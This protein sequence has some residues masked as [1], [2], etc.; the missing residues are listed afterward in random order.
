MVFKRRKTLLLITLL[1]FAGCRSPQPRSHRTADATIHSAYKPATSVAE[2]LPTVRLVSLDAGA[3]NA[4][5][6]PVVQMAQPQALPP[7]EYTF[8][9]SLDEA[10]G[11][12]LSQN[13]DLA[14]VRATEPVA[15]AA[16][17]VANT[18]IY[19]PQFQTQVLPYSRDRNGEDGSVSQQHV[20]VQTFELGGQ[21]QHREGMAAANWRQVHNTVNQAELLNMAQTTRFFFAALYQREL[22]DL[23]AAL[24]EMNEQIIGVIERREK[25]GQSNKADVELAKLQYRATLRQQRLAEAGYQTAMLSLRNQLNF[26]PDATIDLAGKWTNWQWQPLDVV[27][28]MAQP[29]MASE[30]PIDHLQLDSLDDAFLRQLVANR[31]DVLAARSAVSM[32]SENMRLADA[33]RCPSLQGGPMFQRDDSSTVFWGVQAQIDIPVVNNGKPLVQQRLAELRQQ[34]ITA[35]QLENRAV[36]EA[37]AAIQRYERARRLVEQSRADF[38]RDLNE[39]LQPFEDQFKAGQIN[40]LQVFAARTTLIQSQQGFFD[41]LNELTLAMADV[42]QATGMQPQMLVSMT[43][44]VATAENATLEMP[45]SKDAESDKKDAASM[46]KTDQAEAS[47]LKELLQP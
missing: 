37:R 25:A 23:N 18:Y 28:G 42:T 20:V 14:A 41:L 21:Q 7:A 16:M 19:N 39:A 33:M 47:S 22:R 9:L 38:D 3:D 34:Q 13:P 44:S 11:L 29:M 4:A 1:V 10:I 24:A 5:T 32:A 45:S 12:G 15:S 26:A 43:E 17:G 27:V 31:P 46:P 6:N 30:E 8:Q 2:T 40:L 36:L 35:T